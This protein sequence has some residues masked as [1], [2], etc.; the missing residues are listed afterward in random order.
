MGPRA[1]LGA[2]LPARPRLT[3]LPPALSPP[4]PPFPQARP[5]RSRLAPSPPPL[6]WLMY[7]LQ[8]GERHGRRRAYPARAAPSPSRATAP[9]LPRRR[10]PR[11]LPGTVVRSR[12]RGRGRCRTVGAGTALPPT[13][14]PSSVRRAFRVQS[15]KDL[16]HAALLGK[17]TPATPWKRS[18]SHRDL[19]TPLQIK[20]PFLPFEVRTPNNWRRDMSP[21]QASMKTQVCP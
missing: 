5:A 21:T 15:P 17:P 18:S 6:L 12:G 19:P 16:Q 4:L 8:P 20:K 7:S 13:D 11:G 3:G 9:C 14:S 10:R 2:A 1:P